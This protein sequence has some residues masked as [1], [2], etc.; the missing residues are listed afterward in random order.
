MAVVMALLAIVLLPVGMEMRHVFVHTGMAGCVPTGFSSSA[1]SDAFSSFERKFSWFTVLLGWLNLLPGILGAAVGAPLVAREMERG[2]FRLA[3]SQSVTRTR[4]VLVKIGLVAVG[5]IIVALV[6]IALVTW[7]RVPFDRLG[8][9]LNPNTAFDF[10]GT[11]AIGYFLFAFALGTF[12]GTVLRRVIPALVGT[13]IVFLPVRLFI[14]NRRLS[15]IDPMTRMANPSAIGQ[16][17]VGDYVLGVSLGPD[18]SRYHNAG[19]QM[20][21]LSQASVA[22]PTQQVACLQAHGIRAIETYVP[23]SRFWELQLIETS[24]FVLVAGVLLSLTVLI[25]RRR[26]S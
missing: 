5:V 4:W 25:V 14:Q 18:P 1:C 2:T 10:E 22:C 20:H 12:L 3:F 15:F 6:F 23:L 16:Q 9:R 24:G 21:A 7:A 8:S 13:L 17:K 19:Q 26:R 11:V